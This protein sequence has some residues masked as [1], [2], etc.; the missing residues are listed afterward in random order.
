MVMG[1]RAVLAVA[2]FRVHL[3]FDWCLFVGAILFVIVGFRAVEIHAF[4]AGPCFG[5]ASHG[6]LARRLAVVVL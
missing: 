6:V 5:A 1:F 2:V 3:C 4:V